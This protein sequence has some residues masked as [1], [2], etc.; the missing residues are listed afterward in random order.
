MVSTNMAKEPTVKAPRM[1]D[2]QLRDK[3]KLEKQRE[4]I[5]VD[6]A[7]WRETL[8]YEIDY[9]TDEADPDIVEREKTLALI[10]TLE[11]KLSA[12]ERALRL[13]DQGEYGICE[14]CGGEIGAERLKAL[15]ET[16]LCVKCKAE[17]EKLYR[18]AVVR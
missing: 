18:R 4:E 10:A 2:K 16:T 17:T 1:T 14:R 12:I 9:G 15:P 3:S 5:R 7:R 6:L 13:I 8:K 11:E